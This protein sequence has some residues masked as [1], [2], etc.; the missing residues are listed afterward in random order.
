MYV[1]STPYTRGEKDVA[2][3]EGGA[4][5]PAELTVDD[6]AAAAAERG[7]RLVPVEP[8][9]NAKKADWM[10]Y[11]RKLGASDADLVD[12]DGKELTVDA[13]KAKYA[14]EKTEVNGD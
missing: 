10:E 7:Y 8:A 4:V 13:L 6:L 12:D 2:E 9:G 1:A 3:L 5:A 14:S 11:A